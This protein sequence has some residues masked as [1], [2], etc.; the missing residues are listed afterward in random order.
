MIAPPQLDPAQLAVIQQL[1]HT[2][3]SV[4]SVSKSLTPPERVNVQNFPSSSGVNGSSHSPPSFRNEPR[5]MVK[6]EQK[7]N[8]YRSPEKEIRPDPH[9]DERD[10]MRG[11]YRGG[12]RGRGDRFAGRN[13][14][15]RDRDRYRDPDRDQSLPRPGKGGRSRSRSPPSRYT[16][17]RASRFSSPPRRPRA[18]SP[19][20]WQPAAPLRR[21]SDE[22]G[23]D[24][25]GRDIRPESPESPNQAS[26]PPPIPSPK[27]PSQTELPKDPR[28][29]HT[30]SPDPDSNPDS[31][32][33]LLTT[34]ASSKNST[35]NPSIT[36][37]S[38]SLG[39]MGME[40]FDLAKFDYTSPASWEAL[41]NLWQVTNGYLPSTE[42][43][44]QF[45]MTSASRL[46][47]MTPAPEFR[48]DETPSIP[49]AVTTGG[50]ARVGFLGATGYGNNRSMHIDGG[51]GYYD[52]GQATDAVVLGEGSDGGQAV[53]S[54]GTSLFGVQNESALVSSSGRMQRVG[55][56]WVFVR[57]TAVGFS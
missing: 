30:D 5:V 22:P 7:I 35:S 26:Q 52:N 49:N 4:P 54:N 15:A 16:E 32:S 47:E 40:S 45:V 1:A 51:M 56:K 43:L 2:A 37:G 18:V 38:N 50:K 19:Q 10:N 48:K 33:K 20:S 25:F 55:D 17:R 11:R 46:S 39:P 24:E 57:G 36:T 14:D 41:G 27:L 34:N 44:M 29:P 13:W 8:G 28:I 42:Q 9:F 31:N 21:N 53:E 23:K 6:S 3:A 12:I